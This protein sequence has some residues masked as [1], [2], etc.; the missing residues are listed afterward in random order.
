MFVLALPVSAQDLPAAGV[1]T[2][3]LEVVSAG[4]HIMEVSV[5]L[6]S[7]LVE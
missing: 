3:G 7:W 2:E 4:A 1:R 5:S 6:C